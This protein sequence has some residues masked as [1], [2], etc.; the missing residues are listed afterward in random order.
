[1]ASSQLQVSAKLLKN[2]RSAVP[3]DEGSNLVAF[4]SPS[5]QLALASVASNG[6]G[7]VLI[8]NDASD[9]GWTLASLGGAQLASQP[10]VIASADGLLNYFAAD[11]AG[12]IWHSKQNAS[13]PGGWSPLAPV[14]AVRA[15][16]GLE[17]PFTAVYDSNGVAHLLF[18]TLAFQFQDSWE[19]SS[20][21]G[22]WNFGAAA[23]LP[24][25]PP[26]PNPPF[27][28]PPPATGGLKA[29]RD[30]SGLLR[31]F[32]AFAEGGWQYWGLLVQGQQLGV[33]NQPPFPAM[34]P[35]PFPG[36]L[37]GQDSMTCARDTAAVLTWITAAGGTFVVQQ[38]CDDASQPVTLVRPAFAAFAT[39]NQMGCD[40]APFYNAATRQIEM[41]YAGFATNDI[42][43]PI[44]PGALVYAKPID[45]SLANWTFQPLGDSVFTIDPSTGTL[46]PDTMAAFRNSATRRLEVF[47][48]DANLQVQYVA[49]DP[50]SPTGWTE[51][52]GI[53][54][55]ATQIY[56]ALTATGSLEMFLIEPDGGTLV[57]RR[58][59]TSLQWS[60]EQVVIAKSG[61]V[62][63]YDCYSTEIIV[64]DRNGIANAAVPCTV[65]ASDPVALRI[66]GETFHV[67]ATGR[68][69][70]VQ[71]VSNGT[72]TI[73]MATD[74]IDSPE[75]YVAA[76]FMQPGE[77]ISVIP[78]EDVRARIQN[79][80][81]SADKL[82]VQQ[83]RNGQWVVPEPYR[84]D[85]TTVAS[86]AQAVHN[87]A[88]LAGSATNAP[89]SSVN[90]AACLARNRHPHLVRHNPPGVPLGPRPIDYAAIP[91][92]SWQIRFS[93]HRAVYRV[94]SAEDVSHVFDR[95]D[96]AA[97]VRRTPDVSLGSWFGVD[98]D[99]LWRAVTTGAATLST[100]T[101]NTVVDRAT[102]AVTAVRAALEVFVNG[103]L[104]SVS[105]VVDTV[106][107]AFDAMEGLLS[108]VGAKFEDLV[109]WLSFFF[110]WNDILLT[111]AAIK[112]IMTQG[113]DL[114]PMIARYLSD[115]S[116]RLF[117]GFA[118]NVDDFV[119]YL[120]RGPL[121]GETAVAIQR[122]NPPPAEAEDSQAH[123]IV[124]AGIMNSLSIPS[125]GAPRPRM[126]VLAQP[127]NDIQALFTACADEFSAAPGFAGAQAMFT[128]LADRLVTDP[129]AA[130]EWVLSELVVG[131]GELMKSG[132]QAA[133]ALVQGIVG[134]IGAAV[135]AI[136]ATLGAVWDVPFVSDLYRS[137]TGADLTALDLI[138][139]VVAVPATLFYKLTFNS[140]PIT[141]ANLAWMKQNY[142]AT[143]V[144]AASGLGV[145]TA[146]P[147]LIKDQDVPPAAVLAGFRLMGS[148][149]FAVI[150]AG[151]DSLG[152][153][154]WGEDGNLTQEQWSTLAVGSEWFVYVLG[155]PWWPTGVPSVPED[156]SAL[157]AAWLELGLSPVLDL[158]S[159]DVTKKK[160]SLNGEIGIAMDVLCGLWALGWS[161][162]LA[163]AMDGQKSNGERTTANVLAALPNIFRFLRTQ[164]LVVKPECR[165]AMI[166]IDGLTN[167]VAGCLYFAIGLEASPQPP[168]PPMAV[169]LA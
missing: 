96:M 150:A 40:C 9:T 48:I 53:G 35:A 94:L 76:A 109:Q 87:C 119:A 84:A 69:A 33:W 118:A 160:K 122:S 50:A 162:N 15:I 3:I 143:A 55:E 4:R 139:L 66:N 56:A 95:C 123:N 132:I 47:A 106:E 20:M 70:S 17:A 169:V 157:G 148:L 102:G 18:M 153:T 75:L 57:L 71:T 49:Q 142:T 67:N 77:S 44:G 8:E 26:F 23:L 22:G 114:A 110:D 10:A 138:A 167:I 125:I 158:C 52:V 59:P 151:G 41:V 25:L 78:Q 19:D 68:T 13:G 64:T 90:R 107:Q 131:L 32:I 72:L 21:P 163:T 126:T 61:Q 144:L 58:D 12:G 45:T 133:S 5:D 82:L 134:A 88:L 7:F 1:M 42:G 81:V 51:M 121:S 149:V 146:A 92:E 145:P 83:D 14:T 43:A 130:A 30:A 124:M 113:L 31:V 16:P 168:A 80:T 28:V 74:T 85:P 39:P 166:A 161:V 152:P 115:E 86:V 37:F 164:E 140:A 128:R 63:E 103:V 65:W 100:W 112:I 89:S 73:E 11:A 116:G 79:A 159:M 155:C 24:T 108:V 99:S 117:D 105:F 93:G 38:G 2:Y 62:E 154:E 111:K 97:A 127:M 101:V 104:Q 60:D 54:Y 34:S 27:G 136:Q 6:Q 147:P 29:V 91:A 120:L 135:A 36:F 98:W 129:D 46:A 137:L 156:I 141:E 165:Q